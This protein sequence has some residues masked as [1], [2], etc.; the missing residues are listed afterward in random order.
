MKQLKNIVEGEE[1]EPVDWE[2]E[3]EHE[4]ADVVR[5]YLEG[6]DDIE[7]ASGQLADMLNISIDDVAN[8]LREEEKRNKRQR[9]QEPENTKDSHV[10]T[11]QE[12][13]QKMRERLEEIKTETKEKI[14]E[15][16]TPGDKDFEE[17]DGED[18]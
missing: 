5:A 13:I 18:Y 8:L 17:A 12:R 15:G 11:F 3:D 16:Q 10:E 9:I 7:G 1:V 6:I 4:Y 14:Q 2:P